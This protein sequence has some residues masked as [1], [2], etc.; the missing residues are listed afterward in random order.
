ML[1]G[2]ITQGEGGATK[3]VGHIIPHT[4]DIAHATIYHLAH[5]LDAA[6]G[7]PGFDF[8]A[9]RLEE[10]FEVVR[11]LNVASSR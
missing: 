1:S 5:E 11:S 7:V 9:C 4:A 10:S 6:F 3:N 8:N 2:P